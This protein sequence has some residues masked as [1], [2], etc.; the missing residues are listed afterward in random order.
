MGGGKDMEWLEKHKKNKPRYWGTILM[1]IT[2]PGPI[3]MLKTSTAIEHYKYIYYYL[4]AI[5][6][7]LFV[8]GLIL[9]IIGMM[10]NKKFE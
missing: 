4:A 9:F 5:F 3:Y 8:F 6:A 7:F 2:A 10:I 1:I